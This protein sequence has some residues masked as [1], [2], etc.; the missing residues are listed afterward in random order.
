[1]KLN[2]FWQAVQLA[3][4]IAISV[5]YIGWAMWLTVTLWQLLAILVI[6]GLAKL[7]SHPS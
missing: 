7:T 6:Y 5:S 4:L 3:T 1:V 2:L